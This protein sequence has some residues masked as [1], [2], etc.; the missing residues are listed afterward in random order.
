M[1]FSL[2]DEQLTIQHMARQF[3]AKQIAP[4][5]LDWD[6][7]GEL[8][9][10]VLRGAAKLGMAGIYASEDF[11]GTGLN[12]VDAA[13]IFEELSKGDPSVSSFLSIH[14][15]CVWM[16]DQF[17]DQVLKKEWIP[18]LCS[19]DLISS[20]CLTESSSGSDAAALK[21]TARKTGNRYILNGSKAFISGGGF[22][23]IYIVMCRT[24][25]NSPNGISAIIV[26]KETP[27]VSFG[28]NEKKM[29][30]NA[31]PTS[32]VYL[33]DV[34]VDAH[35]LI[36]K[37]G[38][39]F[40]IAMAGLDGGRINIAACSLGAAQAALD[41][42]VLYMKERSAFGK[43]LTSLQAL[44][45]KIADMETELQAARIFLYLAAWKL[46]NNMQ[47]STKYCAMAKRLVTDIGFSVANQ[48]LQLHGGYGYLK[49]YGIEKIVR[50]LRVHQILE[51]TN[52]IMR[53]IISR[54]ML[55]REIE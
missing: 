15:M 24:G 8:P 11:G 21:T 30:W 52:E 22:S 44:Q 35:N 17:G 12:R 45:F 7:S 4:N 13:I 43:K 29:G 19:M 5:A 9:I 54:E 6:E 32:M 34:A 2:T 26:P 25:D 20:Y 39:G 55:G 28:A 10:D 38:E 14:N 23:D 48:A 37:E 40:R 16:I 46:G 51:G 36:G 53:V 31:Q 42:A 27:G 50:D 1:D 41:K 33:E 49:E 3:T 18:K 47:D